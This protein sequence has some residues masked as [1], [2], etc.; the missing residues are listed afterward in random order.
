MN[1]YVC[2]CTLVIYYSELVYITTNKN[3]LF[4]NCSKILRFSFDCIV[5]FASFARFSIRKPVLFKHILQ[6]I[7][8]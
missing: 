7:N 2:I 5:F 1:K 3:E 6:G 4:V 8:T